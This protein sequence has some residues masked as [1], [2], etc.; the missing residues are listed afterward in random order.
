MAREWGA[1]AALNAQSAEEGTGLLVVKVE[2]EEASP[3]AEEAS[4]L[5][6]PGPDRSRQRFRAFRYPEVAGPRQ[7]LSRLRELCR[8][9]LQ[10][11]MHSKE[12]ILELLVL[13]QFLT[14][15]PGELQ[16]W[17]REQHPDSGEEVVALL[18]YLERQLDET[19][20]QVEGT[21]LGSETYALCLPETS[22]QIQGRNC[23]EP[24]KSQSE[25]GT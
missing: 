24:A 15:L 21:G 3:L 1:S 2:Q 19:P 17:V 14:I 10:P 18:E 20:P 13:E 6:S 4:W 11:D 16:A 7:A 5:G 8:Q 22:R 12:Q 23:L 25:L 9:W